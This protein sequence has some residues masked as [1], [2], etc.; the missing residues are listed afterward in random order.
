LP[1]RHGCVG[2]YGHGEGYRDDAYKNV[3]SDPVP[4]SEVDGAAHCHGLTTFVRPE[5]DA[6]LRTPEFKSAGLGSGPRPHNGGAGR[7]PIG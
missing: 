1:E 7:P 2:R 3:P 5:L 6:S 4:V